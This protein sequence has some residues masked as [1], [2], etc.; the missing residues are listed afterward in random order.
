MW[1][2]SFPEPFAKEAVFSPTFVG[3][4]VENQTAIAV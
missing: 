2:S 4:I 1:I 3:T